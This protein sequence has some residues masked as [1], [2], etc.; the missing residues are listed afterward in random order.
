VSGIAAAQTDNGV[1][2][3]GIAGGVKI[4]PV[5]VLDSNNQG[6][7]VNVVQGMI[8]ATDMSARAINLSLGGSV[9]SSTIE[10]LF[11]PENTKGRNLF[12]DPPSLINR[13]IY[14]FSITE[15]GEAQ[16]GA[17]RKSSNV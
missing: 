5:K 8:Y 17:L 4:L 10:S 16:N 7:W 11:L 1:G 15:N 9:P 14:P 2:I 3:A 13:N 12:C 6:T